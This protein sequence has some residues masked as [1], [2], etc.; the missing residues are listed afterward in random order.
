MTE[1]IL[2]A[3]LAHNQTALAE[4]RRAVSLRPRRFSLILA[5][6]NYTRLQARLIEAFIESLESE[7]LESES[8]GLPLSIQLVRLSPRSRNLRSALA[9]SLSP[10]PQRPQTVLMVTGLE[11]V[12]ALPPAASG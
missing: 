2:Q 4:L 7:S 10:D 11:S 3:I 8:L 9:Q 12:V 5:Q 6:C 1:A